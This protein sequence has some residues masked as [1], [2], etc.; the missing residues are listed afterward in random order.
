MGFYKI[1]KKI[2]MMALKICVDSLNEAVQVSVDGLKV[3]WG[4]KII[5]N[6]NLDLG[7]KRIK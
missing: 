4:R 3:W 2:Q 7:G 1:R 5:L 6:F